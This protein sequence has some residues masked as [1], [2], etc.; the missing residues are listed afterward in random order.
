MLK[1]D[2]FQLSSSGLK[3]N[4]YRTNG[5]VLNS[6]T[7][8]NRADNVIDKADDVIANPNLTQNPGY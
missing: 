5:L 7:A 3:L 2:R 1:F 4:S 6:Q 8:N